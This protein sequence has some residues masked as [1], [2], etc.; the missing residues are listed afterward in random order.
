[1]TKVPRIKNSFKNRL[2]A[3][4]DKLVTSRF[5]LHIVDNKVTQKST[6]TKLMYLIHFIF[7]LFGKRRWES[8]KRLRIKQRRTE[9]SSFLTYGVNLLEYFYQ[10]K[11]YV[12]KKKIYCVNCWEHLNM[13]FIIFFFLKYYQTENPTPFQFDISSTNDVVGKSFKERESDVFSNQ[14]CELFIEH[15]TKFVL[16]YK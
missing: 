8:R 3:A 14:S 5:F 6:W 13:F 10:P 11:M 7:L 9:I 4:V 15:F 16:L 12:K 2:W 1:M